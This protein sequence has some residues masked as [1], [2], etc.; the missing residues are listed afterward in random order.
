M[1]QA[2]SPIS[3]G[4]GQPLIS[5]IIVTYNSSQVILP[6]LESIFLPSKPR[7]DVIV[8]DNA[9][10]D[11]TASIVRQKFPQVIL[12]ENKQNMGFAGG[13][14]RA[15]EKAH[16]ELLLLL[17]PDLSLRDRFI[18]S[19][20]EF[21]GRSPQASI[22]GARLTDDGGKPQPSCWETPGLK[23]LRF[24]AFLP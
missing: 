20:L 18:D 23:T 11:S 15:A 7:V 8:I 10:E 6:C 21:F 4:L 17:N 5:V 24:E 19:L 14:G 13:V 2:S 3:K 22:I 9:S 16:G 1:N 12:I